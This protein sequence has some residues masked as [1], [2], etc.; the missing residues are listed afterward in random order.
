MTQ[1]KS[2]L[3]Q[4]RYHGKAMAFHDYTYGYG[5]RFT[6][7]PWHSD[8][9]R[10]QA[11]NAGYQEEWNKLEAQNGAAKIEDHRGGRLYD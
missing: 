7:S 3:E 1:K 10:L 2:S 5:Y 8:T 6:K 4:C 11:F 9:R